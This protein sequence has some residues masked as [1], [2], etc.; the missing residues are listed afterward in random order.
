VF[1]SAG[2]VAPVV[3]VVAV[4]VFLAAMLAAIWLERRLADERDEREDRPG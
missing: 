4:A 3:V 1:G 2:W